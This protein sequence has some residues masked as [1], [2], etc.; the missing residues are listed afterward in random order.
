MR[1]GAIRTAALAV[2]IGLHAIWLINGGGAPTVAQPLQQPSQTVTRL[3]FA[4]PKPVPEQ[5]APIPEPK[6]EP[7]PELEPVVEKPVKK[8]I[9]VA[10]KKPAPKP[11]EKKAEPEPVEEPV[12][13]PPVQ[14]VA[15]APE[16]MQPPAVDEGLLEEI[17]QRYLAELMAHIEAHKWYPKAARRRGIQ[18]EVQVSFILLPDGSIKDIE[19]KNGP[20]VL[21]AA[22]GSAVNKAL[23]MPRPPSQVHCP[24][25]CEFSMRFALN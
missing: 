15:S 14:A 13:E 10:K 8:E 18:G 12:V 19:V 25:H 7:I 2:S 21:V 20:E 5:P 23:P 9:K 24:L 1:D 17:K 11:V 4:A 16:P 3:V 22:A 6:S